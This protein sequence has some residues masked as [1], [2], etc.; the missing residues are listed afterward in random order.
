ME[1]LEKKLDVEESIEYIEN[2][3]RYLWIYKAVDTDD[4][5]GT[6]YISEYSVLIF[7]NLCLIIS[8]SKFILPIGPE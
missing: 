8:R 3:D 4:T 6:E 2:S 5:D 7:K 1:K